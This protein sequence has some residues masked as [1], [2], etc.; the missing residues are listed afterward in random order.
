MKPFLLNLNE[1]QAH[2]AGNLL[3]A[4]LLQQ[5]RG[6]ELDEVLT[7]KKPL[8][9]YPRLAGAFK[10]LEEQTTPEALATSADINYLATSLGDVGEQYAQDD[11]DEEV[12]G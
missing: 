9:S 12:F 10:L 1:Q 6:H 4:M 7:G 11:E 5:V 2:E 8:S 3:S